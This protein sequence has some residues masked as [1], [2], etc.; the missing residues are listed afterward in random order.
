MPFTSIREISQ[1]VQK[2]AS[3]YW[4]RSSSQKYTIL[5]DVGLSDGVILHNMSALAISPNEIDHA[6][7][8]HGH[9]DHY[10]G[11]V[12]L[13]KT[14]DYPLPVVLHPHAFLKR[15]V[16]AG[17]GLVIPYYNPSLSKS[18][19]ESAGGRLVMAKGLVLIGPLVFTTGEIPLK[20]TV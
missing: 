19:L 10:G 4:S 15:Y 17:N 6:V 13:L 3:L 14:R 9:P 12:A 8:S 7:V 20:E 16:V 5:F 1:S 11:L 18:E 2:T